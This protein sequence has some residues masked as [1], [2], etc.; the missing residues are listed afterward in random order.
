VRLELDWYFGH[1]FDQLSFCFAL[2]RSLTVKHLIDHD[3]DGPYV[4]FDGVNVPFKGLRGHIERAA[5]IILLLL[6]LG[7]I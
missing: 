2:P 1:F 3:A 7:T 5:Y 6:R 4:V